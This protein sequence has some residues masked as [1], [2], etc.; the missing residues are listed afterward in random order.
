MKTD[1]HSNVRS[2]MEGSVVDSLK[3]MH[4]H[5]SSGPKDGPRKI[6]RTSIFRPGLKQ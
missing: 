4:Q 6:F 3:I 5:S 2:D 1:Y